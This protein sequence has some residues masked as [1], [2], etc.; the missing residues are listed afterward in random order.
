MED[1]TVGHKLYSVN[2]KR[3]EAL[4]YLSFLVWPFGVM[5]ASL[6][7]WEKPWVK[8]IFWIFCIFFGFTFFLAED[9]PNWSPDSI[10]YAQTLAEYAHNN[11]SLGELWKSIYSENSSNLDIFQPLITYLISRVT[12]NPRILFTV[13]GLIFGYFYSRNVW[14]VLDQIHGKLS[15]ILLL[16]ILAF[17]LF[18]P[19][20]NINGFR[21]WTA[22]QIF[23]FGTLP[24]LVKGEKKRLIWALLSVLVHFSFLY[25]VA[26]LF[27]FL[28]LKNRFNLYFVFF[29]L[30]SIVKEINL[31][32]VQ[33]VLSFLPGIFQHRIE[34]YA[35]PEYAESI[36]LELQSSSWFVTFS[37]MGIR[38][39]VYIMVIS[40]FIFGRNLLK[41]RHDYMTLLCY[42]LFL[43]SFANIFSLIPSGGRFITLANIF[44]FAFFIFFIS[45]YTEFTWLK[46]IK[47]LS[48]PFLL[49]FCVFNIR[50]GMEF[51]GLTT[52]LGNPIF[53]ALTIDRVSLI[54]EIK[55]FL[56]F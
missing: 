21:Y 29:I 35:N 17:C 5:L 12:S 14:Y 30:T 6:R 49:L 56:S 3:N 34:S 28:M 25:A 38:Y 54:N 11:M 19:I 32:S 44:I 16:F 51:F 23:I 50:V 2:D 27:L 22:A 48:V 24:Y 10:R 13:F 37:S 46:L 45:T 7:H 33:S 36:H 53:S 26:S 40:I 42:S 52:I 8:N 55:Q 39:I 1:Q 41:N 4:Y 47:I 43:Y 9:S 15:I 18:N 31:E 20:W